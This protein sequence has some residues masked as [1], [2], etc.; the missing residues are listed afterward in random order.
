MKNN[1]ESGT[2]LYKKYAKFFQ[3]PIFEAGVCLEKKY[4]A[5]NSKKELLFKPL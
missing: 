2:K 1:D 4:F 3:E 5:K